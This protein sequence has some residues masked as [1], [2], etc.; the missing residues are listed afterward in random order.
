M[1]AVVVQGLLEV[2]QPRS[3]LVH[4][5]TLALGLKRLKGKTGFDAILLDLGLPD[6][7]GVDS[8][9]KVCARAGGAPV[10]VLT[11][12]GTEELGA[13][14][15]QAGAEDFL[16]KQH[17]NPSRLAKALD[18]AT[19]R[20]SGSVALDL[21]N[22]LAWFR[23]LARLGAGHLDKKYGTQ[24]ERLF[25]EPN[26]LLSPG[27]D[28]LIEEMGQ[29]EVPPGAV[30]SLHA[31]VLKRICEQASPADRS[32][33]LRTSSYVAMATVGGLANYYLEEKIISR[34]DQQQQQEEKKTKKKKKPKR[35]T[36]LRG[37]RP[38]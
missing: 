7:E 30:F 4:E 1:Q 9:S 13:I 28:D 23:S 22:M 31:D 21:D 34:W 26:F 24:Y 35:R 19:L 11:A 17:L 38:K 16:E 8:V 36:L 37:L 2:A 6:S 15:I 25:C 3:E 27:H 18:F 32:R 33:Y 10:I 5:A 14:C 20:Q 29:A 12:Q